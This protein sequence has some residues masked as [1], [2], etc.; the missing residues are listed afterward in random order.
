M[1]KKTMIGT[2]KMN[3]SD[4]DDEDDKDEN[5]SCFEDNPPLLSSSKVYKD[6]N[7]P[8]PKGDGYDRDEDNVGVYNILYRTPNTF[9]TPF[10]PTQTQAKLTILMKQKVIPITQKKYIN[11]TF[12]LITYKNVVLELSFDEVSNQINDDPESESNCNYNNNK[13]QF[14]NHPINSYN[15]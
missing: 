9:D 1:K 4:F 12:K 10:S 15:S 14:N 11:S 2:Q 5:E 7:I 3:D 6:I 13:Q 8:E